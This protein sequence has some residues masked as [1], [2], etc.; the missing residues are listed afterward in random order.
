MTQRQFC[1]FFLDKNYFGIDIKAV[2]EIIRHQP[3]TRVPLA[4]P[5]ICGLI[6]LRGQIIAVLD[7]QH[8]LEVETDTSSALLD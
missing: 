8:R 6:D 7:L 5:D 2:Q 3:L 4:P 1:T